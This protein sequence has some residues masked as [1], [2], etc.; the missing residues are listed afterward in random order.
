M[1]HILCGEGR[2]KSS[3]ALGFAIKAAGQ[4]RQVTVISLLKGRKTGS[5]ELL[6]RFEP[7]L[8]LFTFEKSEESF[9]DLS[10]SD[11]DAQV[12]N[13]MSGFYFARK[14]L[15]TGECDLLVLDEFLG[16]VDTGIVSA[17]E[18]LELLHSAGTRTE[19]I[20]TGINADEKVCSIADDVTVFTTTYRDGGH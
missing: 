6:S 11:Q 8:K 7:Q 9:K 13:L 5:Y 1:I 10:H 14:V 17:D 19:V 4:G 16:L 18:L 3:A 15:A 12:Q 20:L 2:G